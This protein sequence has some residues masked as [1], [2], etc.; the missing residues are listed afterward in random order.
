MVRVLDESGLVGWLTDDLRL[1][2]VRLY[3]LTHR[4]KRDAE[5]SLVLAAARYPGLIGNLQ[6]A[7][8][9]DRRD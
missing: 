6:V 3:R 4:R 2:N 5:G 9:E 7:R 1:T 8:V